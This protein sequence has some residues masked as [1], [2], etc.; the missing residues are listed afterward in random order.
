M[1]DPQ[2]LRVTVVVVA[3]RHGPYVAQ[4]LQSLL[5]QTED[6]H[7]IV[8]DDASPDDTPQRIREFVAASGRSEKF[9]L[10]LRQHNIGLPAGLNEAL[11]LVRTRYFVYLA[12]DDWSLPDRLARQADALDAAGSDAGLCYTDCLRARPDGSF[13]E[14]RFSENHAEVW[15]P[16]SPDP[17]RDLLL[18]DNWIPAPTVM[19]RTET[20]RRVG[21]FDEQ[22]AYEDHDS[23]VRVARDHRLIALPEALSVH[24]ELDDGLGTELFVADGERWLT[25]QLRMELKQFGHRADLTDELGTRI[26]VRAIRLLKQDRQ[27]PLAATALG[28]VI[29]QRPLARLRF[30]PFWLRARLRAGRLAGRLAGLLAGLWARRAGG[31]HPAED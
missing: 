18:T 13:H 31:R 28:T 9:T 25:G 15:R 5:D 4:C 12:A 19:F 14:E 17:Y 10:L 23:Y 29:R 11:A 8:V 3:Y 16:D 20:L 1:S 6:C 24:R 7:I 30:V 27:V 2:A 22:I 26:A 21:G